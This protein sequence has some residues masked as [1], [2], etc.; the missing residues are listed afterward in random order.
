MAGQ[1][2]IGGQ[3]TGVPL[4]QIN[5]PPFTIVANA[6][7]NLAQSSI[8]LASGFNSISVPTWAVGVIIIPS[9]TNAVAMTLKGVTGDTGIPLSLTAP[10]CLSF[11]ATPPAT[12]GITSASAGATITEVVF[13]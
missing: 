8:T 13:F 2:T 9:V 11:P 3:L 10:S 5:L 12:I 7:N 4:G 1:V 6:A